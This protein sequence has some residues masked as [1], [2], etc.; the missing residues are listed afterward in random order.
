MIPIHT[1]SVVSIVRG[2]NTTFAGEV[3]SAMTPENSALVLRQMYPDADVFGVADLATVLLREVD[4]Y[5]IMTDALD[6]LE[7]ARTEIT[8]ETEEAIRAAILEVLDAV[9]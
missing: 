7:V 5:A 3:L 8:A 4:T 1:G 9:Q 2:L 6:A